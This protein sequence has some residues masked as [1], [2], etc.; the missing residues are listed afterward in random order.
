MIE[1]TPQLREQA[2]LV[3]RIRVVN[4]RSEAA[5]AVGRIVDDRGGWSLQAEIGAVSVH[6]GVIG[7][8]IGVAT[9]VQLVVG[10]IEIAGT[11]DE[12]GFV[13]ALEPG[14][15]GDVENAVG[16]VAV[17]GR[18][19]PALR[20]HGINVFWVDLRTEV[21]GDAGVGNRDAVDQPGHLMAAAD[22]QLIVDDI[23]TGDVIG[24]Q[25]QAVGS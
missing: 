23:G 7:E 11:E 9:E 12:L 1:V 3:L 25:R 13:V 16:A 17:V 5:E 19:A 22:V 6:A 4:Q 21:A 8:A 10:L 15:G 20:L 2:Q 18:V 24:N 14:A